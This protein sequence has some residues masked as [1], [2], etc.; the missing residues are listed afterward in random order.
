MQPARTRQC[1][2]RLA[3]PR[4]SILSFAKVLEARVAALAVG[5]AQGPLSLSA[6]HLVLQAAQARCHPRHA[7][8]RRQ[9]RLPS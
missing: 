3:S 5:A 9:R 7:E 1:R 6:Q 4:L 2:N 8:H